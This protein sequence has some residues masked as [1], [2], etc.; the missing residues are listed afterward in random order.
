MSNEEKKRILEEISKE[1]GYS[2]QPR[3]SWVI[4]AASNEN[5]PFHDHF[6]WNDRI[7]GHK[8]RLEQ[9]RGLIRSVFVKIT[10]ERVG[11]GTVTTRSHL[12]VK[13]GNPKNEGYTN[14]LRNLPKA[15]ASEK[16]DTLRQLAKTIGTYIRNGRSLARQCK[17]VE[18]FEILLREA[19]QNPDEE[20]AA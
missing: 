20:K 1:N 8:Y 11:F 19:F 13:I 14:V 9:A 12:Y 4:K 5:H 3:P 18:F 6:K 17:K 15:I 10:H 16:E 2:G 7:A